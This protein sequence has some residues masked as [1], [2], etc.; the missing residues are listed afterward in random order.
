LRLVCQCGQREGALGSKEHREPVEQCMRGF[1][2]V[3]R[4]DDVDAVE[5][6]AGRLCPPGRE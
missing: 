4:E 1:D 5:Q 2:P 3:R 6:T